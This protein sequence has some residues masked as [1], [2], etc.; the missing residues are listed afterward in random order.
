MFLFKIFKNYKKVTFRPCVHIM[1]LLLPKILKKKYQLMS[2][3][4]CKTLT[5]VLKD[6]MIL[7]N[8]KQ[9]KNSF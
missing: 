9:Q 7:K 4:N 3:S 2:K 1:S 5:Y 6:I 8:K